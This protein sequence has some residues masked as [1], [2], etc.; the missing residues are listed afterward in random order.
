MNYSRKQNSEG[1]T[2]DGGERPRRRLHTPVLPAYRKMLT[3]SGLVL[4]F[5]ANIWLLDSWISRGQPSVPP[6]QNGPPLAAVRA[7][8][9]V[10]PSLP[11]LDIN[12]P[13]LIPGLEQVDPAYAPTLTPDLREIVFSGAGLRSPDYDLYLAKRVAVT[14]PFLT[15]VKIDSCSSPQAE[16]FP[17]LSP[18]GLELLFIRFDSQPGL[19]YA[20]RDSL[21]ADFSAP[22]RWE[23]A[24]RIARGRYPGGAQFID[25]HHV[26]F[27]TRG[28]T[29]SD[30]RQIL[31]MA[32]Q[33]LQTGFANPVPLNFTEAPVP[34]FVSVDGLRS[35]FG[36]PSGL[37]LA[38][39]HV[40]SE[41]FGPPTKI[42]DVSAD[43]PVWVTPKED[44]IFFCSPGRGKR[45]GASRRLWMLR[46]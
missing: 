27:V 3:L 20:R 5:A 40:Q 36:A 31:L 4:L 12:T 26:Q 23:A 14:G 25:M 16:T 17:T 35:Y 28:R 2:A 42:S 13:V 6:M 7:P 45:V 33:T 29:P 39:R 11:G 43:G 24:A 8:R 18:D 41:P 34:Q 1:R 38:A 46:F 22:V 19:F 10:S 44:I 32:R 21:D 30:D 15:P 37:L 9:P